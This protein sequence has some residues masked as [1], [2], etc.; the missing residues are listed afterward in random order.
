MWFIRL[1][2]FC[3]FWCCDSHHLV[4]A[5]IKIGDKFY[6]FLIITFLKFLHNNVSYYK[7]WNVPDLLTPTLHLVYHHKKIHC[8]KKN[9]TAKC[10]KELL[11]MTSTNSPE[12]EALSCTSSKAFAQGYP[13]E[14]AWEYFWE[15]LHIYIIV[16]W[17]LVRITGMSKAFENVK[18]Q[19]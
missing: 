5:V 19:S 3:N 8:A 10:H 7:Y 12:T 17:C 11:S 9:I 15:Y 16:T 2:V 14:T 18:R 13:G 6:V 1:L 4:H